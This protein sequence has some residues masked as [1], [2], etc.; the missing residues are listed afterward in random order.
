MSAPRSLW[1]EGSPDLHCLEWN[2]DGVHTVLL[3]HGNSANAWW[4]EP[5]AAFM[6]AQYRLIAIDLRGHGDSEWVRPAAYSPTDY[7]DDLAHLIETSGLD[8]P[9]VVGHSMGGIAVTAFMQKY[10]LMA[11][12]AIVIDI[13]VSST[14]RRNRFLERL[15]VLPTINYPDRAT[16]IA[17]FRLMPA[18]D[19]IAPEVIEEI[20]RRSLRA[21]ADGRYTMKFDR[22]SFYGGDGL[23]VARA[24]TRAQIPTLL[25]RAGL[26]RIMT[27]EAAERAAASNPLVQLKVIEG[28]HH[29]L[30]LERPSELAEL[31]QGFIAAVA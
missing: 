25:I 8:Q 27:A 23:D 4:W 12:A 15:K 2:P 7:A 10:P 26:S 3:L 19:G 6:P 16:A 18:Q 14:P 24:L 11:R 30:P 21:T 13:A 28:A 9:I 22:E 31:I 29:H 17:R 20:A 5:M 1:V